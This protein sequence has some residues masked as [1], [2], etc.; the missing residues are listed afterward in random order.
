MIRRSK[1]LVSK[2]IQ[3]QQILIICITNNYNINPIYKIINL[4]RLEKM[5]R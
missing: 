2:E 5:G 4:L 3:L 1:L